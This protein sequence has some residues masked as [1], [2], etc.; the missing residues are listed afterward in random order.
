MSSHTLSFSQSRFEGD[1]IGAGVYETET[2]EGEREERTYILIEVDKVN[3]GIKLGISP[4]LIQKYVQGMERVGIIKKLGKSGPRGKAL[5][6][7]G[8]F[9]IYEDPEDDYVSK[10]RRLWYLTEAIERNVD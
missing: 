6:A 5:Y 2:E 7:M 4:S 3:I 10:P 1:K 8:S 9:Q